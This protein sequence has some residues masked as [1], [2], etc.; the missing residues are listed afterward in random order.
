[1][2]EEKKLKLLRLRFNL[3]DPDREREFDEKAADA[4]K[5]VDPL[6]VEKWMKFRHISQIIL[7]ARGHAYDYF[8][9]IFETV[10]EIPG[11]KEKL[12]G[13]Q[14]KMK[15]GH[16]GRVKDGEV[17]GPFKEENVERFVILITEANFRLKIMKTMIHELLHVIYPDLGEEDVKR[18]T[19]KI[20]EKVRIAVKGW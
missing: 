18:E 13:K 10:L 5:R 6:N 7:H 2:G 4:L 3:K 17:F 1:M 8:N 20:F 15:F 11:L 12:K 14:I 16:D 19:E 9:A